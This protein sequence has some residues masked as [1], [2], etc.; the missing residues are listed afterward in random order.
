MELKDWNFDEPPYAHKKKKR[1]QIKRNRKILPKQISWVDGRSAKF[2]IKTLE[3][4][5]KLNIRNQNLLD[6]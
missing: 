5:T 4:C 3:D 1:F 2:R 6:N